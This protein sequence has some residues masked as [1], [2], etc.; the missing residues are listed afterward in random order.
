[1]NE[2][3]LGNTNQ[4]AEDLPQRLS[5]SAALPED[6]GSIASNQVLAYTS[7]SLQPPT[8]VLVDLMP[9][10]GPTQTWC[11]D[12]DAGKHPPRSLFL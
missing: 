12:R 3:L 11:A 5:T 8:T 2:I 1:M 7:A 10:S 9:S 4:G 6:P